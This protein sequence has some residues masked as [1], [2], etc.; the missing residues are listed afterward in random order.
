LAIKNEKP[1]EIKTILHI[2]EHSEIHTV[3]QHYFNEYW[4]KMDI[5]DDFISELPSNI[6]F[7]VHIALPDFIRWMDRKNKDKCLIEFRT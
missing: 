4:A 5:V 6:K 3:L 2:A 1:K 7:D